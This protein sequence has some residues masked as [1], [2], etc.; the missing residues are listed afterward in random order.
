M[1]RRTYRLI[2]LCE[3]PLDGHTVRKISYQTLDMKFKIGGVVV[4]GFY[5]SLGNWTEIKHQ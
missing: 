3:G 5:D 2:K 1:K 4:A